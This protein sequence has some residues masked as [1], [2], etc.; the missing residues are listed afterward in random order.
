[1]FLPPTLKGSKKFLRVSKRLQTT[2]QTTPSQTA[3]WPGISG[4][5]PEEDWSL[6]V[7]DGLEDA[8]VVDRDRLLTGRTAQ[9]EREYDAAEADDRGQIEEEG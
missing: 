8:G 1:M 4:R 7:V 9:E 6:M 5:F 3:I 2:R